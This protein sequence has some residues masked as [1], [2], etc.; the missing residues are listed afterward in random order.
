[1][2]EIEFNIR[3]DSNY[4]NL[5]PFNTSDNF[6]K[7]KLRENKSHNAIME[8][9]YPLCIFKTIKKESE[10]MRKI[11]YRLIYSKKEKL[12]KEK[13]MCFKKITNN[14]L[15]RNLSTKTLNTNKVKKSTIKN[16]KKLIRSKSNPIYPY[17][18]QDNNSHKRDYLS[19]IEKRGNYYNKKIIASLQRQALNKISLSLF[20]KNNNEINKNNFNFI[21]NNINNKNIIEESEKNTLP[22]VRHFLNN[23]I[24][25]VNEKITGIDDYFN[26]EKKQNLPK[27]TKKGIKYNTIHN[28]K[29]NIK[30]EIN[31]PY[32]RELKMTN[33]KIRDL[34]VM[35]CINKIRDP[36]IIKK[37]KTLIYNN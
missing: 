5:R 3:N 2:T 31:K 35:A 22:E 26:I 37:Y 21:L 11:H 10:E 30:K 19:Q 32:E 18:K 9:S 6:Y 12:L 1:M 27:I 34:K 15:K 17:C 16:N 28:K 13:P 29:N 23:R 8:Y 7:D 25:I 20:K 33:T 4:K 24:K 14:N 36:D